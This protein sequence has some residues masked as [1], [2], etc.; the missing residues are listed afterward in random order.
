MFERLGGFTYRFKFILIGA[1][2]AVCLALGAFWQL[3]GVDKRLSISGWYDPQSES[4]MTAEWLDNQNGRTH[5]G[6]AVIMV[7]TKDS[8][9]ISDPDNVAKVAEAVQ[10]F[11]ME[12]R[13]HISSAVGF[14]DFFYGTVIPD[15]QKYQGQAERDKAE[16]MLAEAKEAYAK[17]PLSERVKRIEAAQK[18]FHVI[19]ADGITGIVNISLAGDSDDEVGMSY[20]LVRDKI[21]IPGL[22]VQQAGV[23]PITM[24]IFDQMSKDVERA[25]LIGVPLVAILLFLVFGGIVAMSLPLITGGL[26]I[27]VASGIIS[28][29]S[30]YFSISSFCMSI[31]EL[32]G[33]GIATDYG[34]F[35]VSRFREELAEGYTV[36]TAV[37]RSLM[38]AGRT[39]VM[40]G[41]LIVVALLSMMIFPQNFLRSSAIGA[42]LAVGVAMF[43]SVTLLPAILGVLGPRIDM[44]GITA[45][46]RAQTKHEIENGFWGRVLPVVLRRPILAAIPVLVLLAILTYPMNSLRLGGVSSKYLPKG[47]VARDAQ[48]KFDALFPTQRSFPIRVVIYYGSRDQVNQIRQELN[49]IPGFTDSFHRSGGVQKTD[50]MG[51]TVL[52]ANLRDDN[53]TDSA[54]RTIRGMNTPVP[55]RVTGF[56]VL[57]YD[58]I[59][60]VF[61][62]L[63]WMIFLLVLTFVIV[64]FFSFGSLV[65]PLKAV[66]LSGVTLIAT[67]GALTWVFS[68]GHF[69]D[70]LNF[71]PGPL[72][73]VVM[74]IIIAVVFGLST[75]YEIFLISR[76][77]EAKGT[78]KTT[79]Q[80]IIS[81]TAQTGRIITAA[82]L[83]LIAVALAF[84][85]SDLVLM[86]Y[87]ALG[88][89]MAL[90]LDAT[91]VRMILVP[92]IMII[93]GEDNWW[94]PRWMQRIQE[95]TGLGEITL[96][97][98]IGVRETDQSHG[99]YWERQAYREEMDSK[100]L[101]AVGM[102]EEN[103]RSKPQRIPSTSDFEGKYFS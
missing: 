58:S 96:T 54:V 44:L 67:M 20:R 35:I 51:V 101:E 98:E 75:D 30:Y 40:S 60:G 27:L 45:L 14:T 17:A 13:D 41:F 52:Q 48:D 21:D 63:P 37:K 87:I 64:M 81:G 61:Q 32:I 62:R 19:S 90:I 89:I 55:I 7:S 80:A 91:F 38:S 72:M 24:S 39:V 92:S 84:A 33:L 15:P 76:M 66:L 69:A 34:L 50:S 86:K 79:S 97:S 95:R 9:K 65:L 56:N 5:L 6:D 43:L 74:V 100:V 57:A 102:E 53:L 11:V 42:L 31:I 2:V 12:N 82:A 68:E 18:T 59:Q 94:A 1:I 23:S 85:F 73:S 16:K 88:L 26:T 29:L 77:I 71:T 25:A 103:Q 99:S 8:S 22:E 78:G 83:I 28:V 10:K 4:S 47:N 36:E 70:F 3:S 46:L 93:T 49:Q